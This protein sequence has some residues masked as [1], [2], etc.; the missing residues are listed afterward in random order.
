MKANQM[1]TL[2]L[3]LLG[4]Y[5]LIVFVPFVSV[6]SSALYYSRSGSNHGTVITVLAALFC[7]LWLAVG[8]SLIVFSVS[9][10]TKLTTG[11]AESNVTSLSFDQIQV[12]AFAV[13]GALI[14]AE[15][16]PQIFNSLYSFFTVIEQLAHKDEYPIGTR[17][18]SWPAL[19]NAVGTLLKAGL[20]L[21]LF[22]G[23]RGAA[24]FWRSMRDFG[25]PKPPVS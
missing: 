4:I 3:R 6:F 10:G 13:A 20:G 7:F 11:F 24:N 23:A 18:D 21:W 19:L 8:I 14:F 12:L 15:S 22:F 17:F 9:W 5:C 1:A 2:V 25:T 16:L